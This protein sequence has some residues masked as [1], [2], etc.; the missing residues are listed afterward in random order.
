MATIDDANYEKDLV[1]VGTQFGVASVIIFACIHLFEL[2]R[3]LPRFRHLFT[4]RCRLVK[5]PTPPIPPGLYSWLPAVWRLDERFYYTHVGLDAVMHLRFLRMA[6]TVMALGCLLVL[7]STLPVNYISDEHARGNEVSQF[8]VGHLPDNSRFLWIHLTAL[9]LFSFGILVLLHRNSLDYIKM[10]GDTLALKVRSGSIVPRSV[11]V[12][13]VPR[14]LRSE[15]ALKALFEGLGLGAVENA[16]MIRNYSKLN[17]R[18]TQRKNI[19]QDLEQAHLDL[20]RGFVRLVRRRPNLLDPLPVDYAEKAPHHDQ[21]CADMRRYLQLTR[22]G[23]KNRTELE[24]LIHDDPHFFW[25]ALARLYRP[26]LDACQPKIYAKGISELEWDPKIDTYLYKLSRA[27][28]RV[29]QLR[30]VGRVPAQFK[31][32][33]YGVVTFQNFNSAQACVQLAVSGRIHSLETRACP[34][35]RDLLWSNFLMDERQKFVRTLVVNACVWTLIII[36]LV[37]MGS[38]LT[39][40]K[41]DKLSK[42]FPFL[43]PLLVQNQWLQNI[44]SRNLPSMLVSLTNVILPFILFAISRQ[45]YFPSHSALERTVIRRNF[46]FAIFN[47]LIFFLV[48]PPVID[49][50]ET[51][52][53]DPVS[54]IRRLV[55]G[56]VNQGDAFFVNYVIFTCCSHYLE[57]AQI[58]VPLFSTLVADNR[59]LLS[60]PRK[61]Q[62]YRSPWSFPYFYYLP[63]HLLIFVITV[64]F[65]CLSPL[66]IPFALFYFV[67]AYMVYKHQFAYAYV[68]QYEANGRFWIDITNFCLFGVC[69]AVGVFILVMALKKAIA[70]AITTVPLFALSIYFAFYVRQ[71][72]F[73]RMRA[74]PLD[75]T[76]SPRPALPAPPT[77]PGDAMAALTSPRH[78]S[79]ATA[80][81]LT[82]AERAPGSKGRRST[83]SHP[84]AAPHEAPSSLSLVSEFSTNTSMADDDDDYEDQRGGS[85]PTSVRNGRLSAWL[86]ALWQWWECARLT[87]FVS[88]V[89]YTADD[90]V[91]LQMYR[92]AQP[93]VI[94]SM[95]GYPCLQPSHTVSGRAATLRRHTLHRQED[96]LH[97]REIGLMRAGMEET[98]LRLPN[99]SRSTSAAAGPAG[100]GTASIPTSP[101]TPPFSPRGADLTRPLS[102]VSLPES[103]LSANDASVSNLKRTQDL[104]SPLESYL[105]PRLIKPLTRRLWLPCNPLQRLYH[106]LERECVELDSALVT[107][108]LLA[109][110]PAAGRLRSTHKIGQHYDELSASRRSLLDHIPYLYRTYEVINRT[111][112][113]L[114]VNT[115]RI[116]GDRSAGSSP[117]VDKTDLD[118]PPPVR[119]RPRLE[120]QDRTLWPFPFR[121]RN[122][123]S[124]SDFGHLFTAIR[125]SFS[126]PDRE[127]PASP[128]RVEPHPDGSPSELP[129]TS[130]AFPHGV[131]QYDSPRDS[132]LSD[133]PRYVLRGLEL[134]ITPLAARTLDSVPHRTSQITLVPPRLAS[135]SSP[136]V[137][138]DAPRTSLDDLESSSGPSGTRASRS[139]RDSSVTRRHSLGRLHLSSSSLDF[140]GPSADL[141]PS[142]TAGRIS[143]SIWNALNPSAAAQHQPT[144]ARP[145]IVPASEA[146]TLPGRASPPPSVS[147][148]APVDPISGAVRSVPAGGSTIIRD[149]RDSHPAPVIRHPL[150]T[151]PEHDPLHAAVIDM[152]DGHHLYHAAETSEP[153]EGAHDPFASFGYP[154][155]PHGVSQTS[156]VTEDSEL[157]SD[158]ALSPCSD[159][160]GS[161]TDSCPESST[162]RQDLRGMYEEDW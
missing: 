105:H 140:C 30:R 137:V 66:I 24:A 35:P 42:V 109:T 1:G 94:R 63:T 40:A 146:R 160:D 45:Q 99:R 60:T 147:V 77:G 64:S 31:T 33:H 70:Q 88:S 108:A 139:T 72:L 121:A 51:W 153:R 101:G 162:R 13:R 132:V 73:P 150:E 130:I 11:L 52:I 128:T 61:A 89:D 17:R 87:L 54:V 81:F 98:S 47:L 28:R 104:S 117:H 141:A 57:L 97:A 14:R 151:L 106:N 27:E 5:N 155:R 148:S 110:N 71:H 138:L 92:G 44:I 158:D 103:D 29:R 2:M 59:W 9:Y 36:W 48:G 37:P 134:P 124:R 3:K 21:A 107:A 131:S 25:R 62:R 18:V 126:S 41:V 90:P 91:M 8:S 111:A 143:G 136:S 161:D 115:Q 114:T 149:G 26:I 38:F 144:E 125:R 65:A 156:G 82:R 157:V 58:G 46:Y 152:G 102:L 159:S 20:A 75:R 86:T 84:P 113:D 53:Q 56:F 118:E 12:S 15:G 4:P 83:L 112:K 127:T 85:R 119:P 116:F 142:S 74:V 69:F 67:S 32:T 122:R 7:A 55:D 96:P 16:T 79:P 154:R 10:L 120:E 19:M 22:R 135:A 49:S 80:T 123:S 68:K 76:D 129:S 23:R 133:H 93:R 145:L 95:S 50:I 43:K 100:S 6:A 39:L 78:L 34:E